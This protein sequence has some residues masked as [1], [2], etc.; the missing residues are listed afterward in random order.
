[1]AFKNLTESLGWIFRSVGCSRALGAQNRM[2]YHQ[3]LG[4]SCRLEPQ[5]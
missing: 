2:L 5:A 3:V 1:M 4:V